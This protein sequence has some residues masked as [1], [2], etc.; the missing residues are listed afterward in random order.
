MSSKPFS[1]G[2]I[3]GLG[4][5]FDY[6]LMEAIFNRRCRRFGLGMEIDEGPNKF[7]SE[8]EPIPLTELEEAIL[9]LGSLGVTGLNLSDAPW[10]GQFGG[11]ET[12][13]RWTGRTYPSPCASHNTD[14]IYTNDT[15]VYYVTFRNTTTEEMCE[16]VNLDT[17]EKIL[18][19]FRRHRIKLADGRL[20]V[21]Y[22]MPFWFPFNAWDVN[23]PGTTLFI[24]VSEMVT[25]SLNLYLTTTGDKFRANFVDEF[26]GGID[27]GTTRW[28]E[29]GVLD[30]SLSVPMFYTEQTF[31]GNIV[32]E[33]G[34]V[35]QLLAMLQN[36]MGLG[37]FSFGGFIDFMIMGATPLVKGLGFRFIAP[38]GELMDP[39]FPVPVGIDRVLE[40]PTIPYYDSMD[41]A[42]DAFIEMK[43]GAQGIYRNDKLPS[44]FK[45]PADIRANAHIPSR[46]DIQ[47]LKDIC[48]YCVEHY[49][50]FPALISP[51]QIRVMHQV[52]HLDLDFY[53]RY[54][55]PGAYTQAHVDHW[56]NWHPGVQVKFGK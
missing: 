44:A 13:L 47:I 56:R 29:A 31:A 54:Y 3:P 5:L 46:D 21:P 26:K 17:E 19:A 43:F 32:A 25:E 1:D 11:M 38:E 9:V 37:G 14:L 35:V 36:A 4:E 23:R 34:M 40:P 16:L 55:R 27:A 53:D 12:M 39:P 50:R 22:Q 41:E 33:Q 6:R 30:A 15:G 45:D 49:G 18:D 20:D 42:V 10:Q 52:H 8:H 51:I 24:P 48:N 2:S 28:V 7:K